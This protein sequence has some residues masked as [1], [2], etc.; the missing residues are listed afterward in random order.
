MREKG[1]FGVGTLGDPK[2]CRF[3][4]LV[5]RELLCKSP[6]QNEGSLKLI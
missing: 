6:F 4:V 3:R 2:T 5:E 1:K